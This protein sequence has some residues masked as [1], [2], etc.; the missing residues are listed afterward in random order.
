MKSK[1]GLI[2]VFTALFIPLSAHAKSVEQCMLDELPKLKVASQARP[3]WQYCA[4]NYEMYSGEKQSSSWFGYEDS[5][6]CIV[7]N[8]RKTIGKSAHRYVVR[9]CT[10]LYQA[11]SG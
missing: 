5:W 2:I 6:Q 1:L 4:D 7:D 3:T 8:K 11:K 10:T 9:A